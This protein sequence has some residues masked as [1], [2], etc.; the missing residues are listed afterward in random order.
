MVQSLLVM[1]G[2]EQTVRARMSESHVEKHETDSEFN[3]LKLKQL[4]EAKKV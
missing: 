1:T 2:D 3:L 4:E